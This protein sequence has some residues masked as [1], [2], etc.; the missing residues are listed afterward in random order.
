MPHSLSE[1]VRTFEGGQKN[2][3]LRRF[4]NFILTGGGDDDHDFVDLTGDPEVDRG[5]DLT[6]KK[7]REICMLVMENGMLD[8][9]LALKKLCRKWTVKSSQGRAQTILNEYYDGAHPDLVHLVKPVKLH[10]VYKYGSAP[11]FEFE[12]ELPL[13]SGVPVKSYVPK[14][15][16]AILQQGID[17]QRIELDNPV[18]RV[19]EGVPGAEPQTILILLTLRGEEDQMDAIAPPPPHIESSESSAPEE[20]ELPAAPKNLQEITAMVQTNVPLYWSRNS[21]YL[22]TQLVALLFDRESPYFTQFAPEIFQ[23]FKLIGQADKLYLDAPAT[24]A[25]RFTLM[26]PDIVQRINAANPRRKIYLG[27]TGSTGGLESSMTKNRLMAYSISRYVADRE[28]QITRCTGGPF[29]VR[30]LDQESV[31][32]VED[33][34]TFAVEFGGQRVDYRIHAICGF[35]GGHWQTLIRYQENYYLVNVTSY[36]PTVRPITLETF[37]ADFKQ[38]RLYYIATSEW[39]RSPE[40]LQDC[41]DAFKRKI[42]HKLRL[43]LHPDVNANDPTNQII[44]SWRDIFGADY[45]NVLVFDL[46]ALWATVHL[47]LRKKGPRFPSQID[48]YLRQTGREVP[49]SS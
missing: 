33:L 38:L 10:L 21:C 11:P 18:E 30:Q 42:Q 43:V 20:P 2:L 27:E 26:T 4:V 31:Q 1:L 39:V 6:T 49:S 9:N 5:H 8:A 3:D 14:L 47:Q 12:T 36:S 15:W 23:F 45:E 16:M 34:E 28:P 17:V 13:Q 7:A 48:E 32:R 35:R 41:D 44:L 46:A 29:A 19:K 25:Q 40:D 24:A 22:D 37:L